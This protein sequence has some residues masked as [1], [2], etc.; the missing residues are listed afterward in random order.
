MQST[1]N[2][3][4]QQDTLKPFRQLGFYPK[5]EDSVSGQAFGVCPFCIDHHHKHEHTFYINKETHQWDCKS[6][7]RDGGFQT[8]LRET[9]ELGKERLN[10]KRAVILARDRGIPAQVIRKAGIG[11]N[12]ANDTYILPAW[13]V[14]GEKVWNIYSYRIEGHLRGTATCSLPLLGWEDLERSQGSTGTVLVCEGHWDWLTGRAIAP[15]GV[16]VVGLPGST[17][18]KPEWADWFSNKNVIHVPD[19]D[20]A[21]QKGAAKVHA[22]I[23]R[24]ASSIKYVHWPEDSPRKYDLRDQYKKSGNDTYLIIQNLVKDIPP[25]SSGLVTV[26]RNF[27]G[28]GMKP[29]AVYRA[30][31]K[32]FKYPG[33]KGIDVIDVMYGTALSNRLDNDPVWMFIVGPSGGGKSGPLMSMIG[34]P[35]IYSASNFTSKSLISGSTGPGGSDPSLIPVWD[36][37]CVVIKDFTVLLS[38]PE[39][40]RKEIFS[41][42]RDAHDGFTQ[43]EV[44]TGNWRAYQCHFSIIAGVTKAIELE[45]GTNASLGE[46]F[47]RWCLPEYSIREQREIIAQV[48]MVARKK[49]KDKMKAELSSVAQKV[50]DHEFD[51]DI[52][53]TS[54]QDHKIAS[55]GIYA[56]SLRAFVHRVKYSEEATHRAMKEV[57]TRIT[58]AFTSLGMG[59]EM[60]HH[61]NKLTNKTFEILKH[62]ARSSAPSRSHDIVNGMWEGGGDKGY[63]VNEVREM[64]GLSTVVTR[65]VLDDLRMSGVVKKWEEGERLGKTTYYGLT[66][67][68][69]DVIQDSELFN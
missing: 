55:L 11:Y 22:V 66:E 58:S 5:G 40:E 7:G 63:E 24:K 30:Y 42:L 26:K 36:G 68:I 69:L 54:T 15:S 8:F 27:T 44:G 35:T 32:W 52:D 23:G 4:A 64:T 47:I 25:G 18:M 21:G 17:Q 38:L 37:N 2:E 33:E 10:K 56:A 13:D 59:I 51:S 41:V 28:T 53:I 1:N 67:D 9:A 29:E 49:M 12:L 20:E 65:R 45:T 50:L 60:F 57:A 48:S 46:R 19:H 16:I 62:T 43:R 6:C 14:Y 61:S 3:G 34:A 31:K 39:Y